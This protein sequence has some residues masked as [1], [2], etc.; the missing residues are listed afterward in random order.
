MSHERRSRRVPASLL[1]RARAIKMLVMDVDGI[2]T[3]GRLLYSAAGEG[4]MAFHVQD[5]HGIKLAQRCGL[6]LAIITGRESEMVANRA[7]ELGVVE[8]HQKALDKLA[9]FQ[10]LLTR[11]GL[12]EAQVAC[13]G[14]DLVDLPLLLR[15]GLAL[16]VP[17]AVEEVR[18]AAHYV[19]RRSGGH[20]AVR[21]AIE[22]LLRAQGHWLA[23]MER[24]R[25]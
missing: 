2:L 4:L 10:D 22:L 18:A 9:V 12:T 21:E 3:D 15:A 13:M 14:D 1:R 11:K 24:Y 16:T 25:R 5:G 6:S 23:V 17:G 20:G 19:T 7:R 8:V